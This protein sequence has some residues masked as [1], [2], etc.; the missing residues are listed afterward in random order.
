MVRR[1]FVP[2]FRDCHSRVPLIEEHMLSKEEYLF[3][4]C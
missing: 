3:T 4:T 2:A 1:Y